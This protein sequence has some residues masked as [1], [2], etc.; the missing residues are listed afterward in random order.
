LSKLV[1]VESPAKA[2]T[3]NRYLGK[4]YRVCASMGHVRDL[5]KSKLG[6]DIEHDFAPTYSVLPG[7]KKI[8]GEIRK[9]AQKA[10]EVFLATDLDREGEAI[11]WHLA[12]ALRLPRKR[13]RRVIF[14]EITRDAIRAAFEE[15][16][17]IDESKVNAQQARRILD[18]L[19]GYRLSP[20]L[21]AKVAR[22]LSAGRVQSVTVKLIVERERQIEAFKPE[23]YWEIEADLAPEKP[24]PREP[25]KFRA[26]LA[27]VDGK[28]ALIPNKAEAGKL[29]RGIKAAKLSVVRVESKERVLQ[30]AP[31]FITSTLQQQASIR[32]RFRT[33]R[34]MMVAQQLYEGIELGE[35]GSAGLITYMR[36]DSARIAGQAIGQ[37]RD[38]ISGAFSD[39]YLPEKPRQYRSGRGAQGAHEAVR[40]TD[41]TQTPEKVRPF[42]S[43][44]QFRLYE[45]I[46]KRFV[47][48]QMVPGRMAVTDVDIKAGRATF[49]VQGRHLAFDGHL[50]VMGFDKK[51]EVR[52]PTL[53]EGDRVKLLK[54]EPSQHFTKPPPRY[55]EASL[56]KALEKL[57]IGRPSTYA[58]IISTIQ[59][60]KY[61]ELEKRQFRATDLG[62]IVTDQ[63]VEHFSD[64]MDVQFTSQ[65]EERLDDVE[66][67]K[68]DWRKALREFY[69][70][71]AKDLKSA[72]KNMKRP[73]PEKTEF[74][75]EK[76]DKPMLKRWS[77]RG[78][79]LGCSGY[80]ECRF[81]Q[82]LDAEG[83]PAPRPEPEATD[84]K[85][86]KCSAP[87]V[88]RTGRH[89]RFLACSAY[90]KCKNTQGLGGEMPPV[91]EGMETCENC[92]KAMAVRRG[93]R[94]LF[95][96]C[97]GYPACRNTKP[98]PKDASSPGKTPAEEPA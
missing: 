90:P 60:R 72:E 25:R 48:C 98:L 82:P 95:L 11:A 94:G 47:A 61:V 30:P 16:L 58:P 45:L 81:T 54:L 40:P 15:P 92:G 57:G 14:N 31:P 37:C 55:T 75:C 17:E 9:L 49:S 73:E 59:L 3:I 46:W 32:L 51:T 5:P 2:R 7:R 93:R 69:V 21:W 70:P 52:L 33:K 13:T 87:M 66:E 71:F 44:D 29:A 83:K 64:I 1:I 35:Q 12:Q 4:G 43:R 80:P 42:L 8:V 91:P 77:P 56:V 65:M 89:G 67:A 26:K 88:I 22:G 39:K 28:P 19:V 97:S 96:G 85:C 6:V 63:L 76:C 38:Y 23:E 79:F 41:V 18:R 24:R 74:K 50:R 84:E 78:P 10:D 53:A 62:K 20:L 68:T 34:T 36:T 27:K 86:E